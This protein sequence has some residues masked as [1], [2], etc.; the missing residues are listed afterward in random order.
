MTIKISGYDFEG[1]YEYES[2]LQAKSGVYAVLQKQ[3]DGKYRLLDAGES[4]NVAERIAYH[5]RKDCWK[6][7]TLNYYVAVKYCNEAERMRIE[8]EVR[9]E[10]EP[11][12]GDR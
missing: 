3:N 2:Y 5:D 6:K 4:G 1:P 11:P 7:H 8:S 12:C 9:R 10:Y